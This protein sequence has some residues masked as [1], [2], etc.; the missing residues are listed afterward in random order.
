MTVQELIAELQK[1]PLDAEVTHLC[2]DG[3]DDDVQAVEWDDG[4]GCVMMSGYAHWKAQERKRL[5]AIGQWPPE[6]IPR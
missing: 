3:Y 4:R 6:S 2:P 5:E 1:H